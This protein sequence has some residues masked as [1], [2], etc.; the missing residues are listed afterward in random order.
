MAGES[1]SCGGLSGGWEK[2]LVMAGGNRIVVHEAAGDAEGT[3]PLAPGQGFVVGPSLSPFL[4]SASPEHHFGGKMYV[5]LIFLSSNPCSFLRIPSFSG[6]SHTETQ[7]PVTQKPRPH[8]IHVCP[9]P[10]PALPRCSTAKGRLLHSASSPGVSE[11][12]PSLSS[13]SQPTCPEL[14]LVD[15]IFLGPMPRLQLAWPVP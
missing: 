11:E 12:P 6:P 9:L 2:T 3:E 7:A 15:V 10:R 5:S 13:L 14:V 4:F 1:P 8:A